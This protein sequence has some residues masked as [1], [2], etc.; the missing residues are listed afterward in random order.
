MNT[1]T[2]THVLQLAHPPI[3]VVRLG[4]IGLGNRGILTL[5]RYMQIEGIEIKA[6]CEIREGN[7]AKAQ[8]ILKESKFPEA[9]GYT[10]TEGWK[11]MCDRTDID[12]VFICT[13]WLTHTPMA[14]YAMEHG[15]HVAIEVPAAMTVEECWKLVDTAEKTR[16]HCM[17]LENC[18]YDPFA[19]T[20]LNM[21]QQGVFG[22]VIHVE[23]AYIHD[24]RS[25]YFAD[26]SNG[27]FHNH[28]GKN[29]SI[30]HTGNPY[31][32]HGLGPICQILNIHRGDKM[33]FLVSLS[34]RQAGMTAYARKTFGADSSEAKQ[35]YLLGDMNTTLI[36][37]TKGKSIMIQYNVVTPRPYSRLHTI[38]GTEG[39]A[40]KYPV[41]AIALEPDASTPL[42]GKALEEIMEKY[43]HP[44][45]ARY[46]EEARRRNLPNEMNY[47]M[48]CRLIYC[49][50]NGLPLDMDVYDAAE[51]S[52]ITELSEQSVLNGSSPVEIPDFTRGSW[53]INRS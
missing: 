36:Q 12:L 26:E 10:G 17:M 40:Q 48:D 32:T 28:W 15:K 21:A 41:P 53:N 31:P 5:Q 9:I 44:F 46:G 39:F 23:G 51:W 18:C 6:L 22:E 8:Q 33:N 30:N 19:L 25:I 29:Y 20:T 16:Q 2:Q 38:C 7:L 13:D 27:G 4:F 43:K 14:T 45:T 24:L 34:S 3:P 11:R 35:A 50:R 37:T 52:C 49:L 42:A 47:V 1:P